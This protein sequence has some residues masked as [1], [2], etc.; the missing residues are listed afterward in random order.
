MLGRLLDLYLAV[1]VVAA[2]WLTA[3]GPYAESGLGTRAYYPAGMTVAFA[4]M[5]WLASVGDGNRFARGLIRML[6][7]LGATAIVAALAFSPTAAG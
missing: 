1:L 6:A 7:A 4:A 3:A 5:G 2:I